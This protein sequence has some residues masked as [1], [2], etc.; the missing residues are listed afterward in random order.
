[1][2]SKFAFNEKQLSCQKTWYG[3]TDEVNNARKIFKKTS[4]ELP[5]NIFPAVC[6]RLCVQGTISAWKENWFYSEKK[7]VCG[8]WFSSAFDQVISFS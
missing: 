5:I 7:N 1:M 6:F 8:F 3:S 4:V 2:T